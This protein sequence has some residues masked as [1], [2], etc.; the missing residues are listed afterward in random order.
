MVQP[1]GD[2][3]LPTLGE[4]LHL[5]NAAEAVRHDNMRA[6]SGV[7]ESVMYS[8]SNTDHPTHP[9]NALGVIMENGSQDNKTKSTPC[10]VWPVRRPQIAGGLGVIL[11]DAMIRI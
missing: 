5:A 1:V 4:L 9:G 8:S 3:R 6:F 10:L 11:T 7:A 2:W